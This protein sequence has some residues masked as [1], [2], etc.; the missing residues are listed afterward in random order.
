[1][2][3]ASTAMR[4]LGTDA[5][6][7]IPRLASI[8]TNTSTPQT[9]RF[10]TASAIPPIPEAWPPLLALIRS[11]RVDVRRNATD[12]LSRIVLTTQPANN[13]ALPLLLICAADQDTGVG[14]AAIT[15]I[16]FLK[17]PASEAIPFM[18]SILRT[19]NSPCCMAAIG[20]LAQMGPL[21]EETVP[22]LLNLLQHTTKS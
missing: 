16:G 10:L 18:L 11:P 2:F 14:S 15:I 20:A 5:K 6:T 17:P 7:A 21:A 9:V 3:G 19:T 22:D 1:M 8:L 12:A 4:K 13:D